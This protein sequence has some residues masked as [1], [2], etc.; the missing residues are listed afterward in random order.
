M[1]DRYA[2]LVVTL[3]RDIREDDAEPILDAI[4]LIRGVASVEPVIGDYRTHMAEQRARLRYRKLLWKVFEESDHG[5][6]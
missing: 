5:N 4:R 6:P 1:T 2:G 3:E